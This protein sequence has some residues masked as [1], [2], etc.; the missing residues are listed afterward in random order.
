MHIGLLLLVFLPFYFRS[1]SAMRTYHFLLV[2]F[3]F[4]YHPRVTLNLLAGS[5]MLSLAEFTRLSGL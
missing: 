3:S 5:E 2:V 4:Y 1:L